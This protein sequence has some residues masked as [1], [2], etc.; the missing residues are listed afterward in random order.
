MLET[1]NIKQENYIYLTPERKKK[2]KQLTSPPKLKRSIIMPK[3]PYNKKY[4]TPPRKENIITEPP[5]LKR[6][7]I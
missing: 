7:K 4:L 1:S 3:M 5:K 2:E 6:K